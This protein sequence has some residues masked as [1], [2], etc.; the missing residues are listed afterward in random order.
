MKVKNISLGELLKDLRGD[1]GFRDAAKMLFSFA[2]EVG[3]IDINLVEVTFV[4]KKKFNLEDVSVEETAKLFLETDELK[5]YLSYVDKHRNIM[6]HTLIYTIAFI[7]MCPGGAI[8]LKSKESI[9][10]KRPYTS[11][12]RS[13]QKIA[14]VVTSSSN[15]PKQLAAFAPLILMLSS[16]RN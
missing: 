1:E 12:K 3:L 8:A 10:R 14:F 9:W 16:R 15:H 2:K 7:G 13:T 4:P 5:A 11:T 6:Y